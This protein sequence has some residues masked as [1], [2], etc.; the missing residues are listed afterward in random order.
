MDFDGGWVADQMGGPL[1]VDDQGFARHWLMEW[2]QS[3]TFVCILIQTNI[4]T[5]SYEKIS[6]Y[7]HIE[8]Y[9]NNIRTNICMKN[10][11]SIHMLKQIFI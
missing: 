6:N 4:R 3:V 8:N 2:M 10:Y 1:W 7:V 11:T 9:M 5:Y